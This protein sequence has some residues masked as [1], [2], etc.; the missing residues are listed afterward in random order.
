M[1]SESCEMDLRLRA[2][3]TEPELAAIRH[4]LFVRYQAADKYWVQQIDPDYVYGLI[5]SGGIPAVITEGYL[6]VFDVSIPWHNP[7]V[8]VLD[9][10]MVLRISP[11]PGKFSSVVTSL[12]ILAKA[13]ECHAIAVGDALQ[14]DSRLERVYERYGFAKQCNQL[15]KGTPYG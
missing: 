14:G 4:S 6:I 1:S 8:R 15:M 12:D 5:E 3:W 7:N 9:E 2:S 11:N 10:R 13:Y